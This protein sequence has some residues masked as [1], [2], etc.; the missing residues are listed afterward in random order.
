MCVLWPENYSHDDI[1]SGRAG[2]PRLL[3]EQ[4]LNKSGFTSNSGA[5]RL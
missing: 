4:I 3:S 5:I 2:T 1:I